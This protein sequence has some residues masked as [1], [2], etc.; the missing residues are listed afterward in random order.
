MT[1]IS[2]ITFF[3]IVAI[4]LFLTFS[5]SEKIG[6]TD[7]TASTKTCKLPGTNNKCCLQSDIGVI[8]ANVGEWKDCEAPNIACC[9]G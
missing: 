9:V 6:K 7:K 4:V 3:V 5:F 1:I 2:V 8:P